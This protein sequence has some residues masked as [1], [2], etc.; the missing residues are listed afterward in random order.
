MSELSGYSRWRRHGRVLA[1]WLA[2][3]IS[4]S[5]NLR[6]PPSPPLTPLHCCCRNP[7]MRPPPAAQSPHSDRNTPISHLS[8]HPASH[9]GEAE[10]EPRAYSL[11]VALHWRFQQ[12]L[13]RGEYVN[14]RVDW[15]PRKRGQKHRMYVCRDP[16]C[17]YE[18]RGPCQAGC[19]AAAVATE[20]YVPFSPR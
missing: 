12:R 5:S 8:I 16:A 15:P 1:V 7:L 14:S 10:G 20:G 11:A 2:G 6:H 3:G 9:L 13:R 17:R 18:K 4:V 19:C